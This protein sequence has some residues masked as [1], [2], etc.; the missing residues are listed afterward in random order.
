VP[1]KTPPGE[2]TSIRGIPSRRKARFRTLKS[3]VERLGVIPQGPEVPS[4]DRMRAST[5]RL[6]IVYR[7]RVTL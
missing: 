7:V 3:L 6:K 1:R 2:R 4:E 5:D